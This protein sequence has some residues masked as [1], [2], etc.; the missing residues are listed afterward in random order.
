MSRHKIDQ[1]VHPIRLRILTELSG[2]PMSTRQLAEIMP[3]VPQATLYRHVAALAE[4]NFLRVVEIQEGRGPVERTYA[5]NIDALRMTPDDLRELT[6][7]E[8]LQYFSIFAAG[9]I[10]RF[11]EYI[12][13]ADPTR[14]GDDGMSYRQLTLNLSEA[15]QQQFSADIQAIVM[16]YLE[17]PATPDRQRMIVAAITIPQGGVNK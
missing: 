12:R 16:R 7:E 17:N 14:I 8:H 11:G 15:E 6:P 1:I 2:R 13:R 4:A 3:D 5:L 9:L 10:D